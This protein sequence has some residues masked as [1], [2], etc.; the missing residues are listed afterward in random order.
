MATT[1]VKDFIDEFRRY[2]AQGERAMAQVSD[3]ALN[4]VPVAEGNSIAMIVRHIGGNLTSRFTD[5]LTTDGEKPTRDRDGEFNERSYSRGEIEASW[6]AGF[7]ALE[8]ALASI[9]EDELTRTVTIR[10]ASLTVHEALCRSLAHTAQHIGQIVL[11][12]KIAAGADW[13]TLTIPRGQS[14]LYAQNPKFEK[15]AAY[16]AAVGQGSGVGGQGSGGNS[17]GT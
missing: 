12:A 14:A 3:D 6:I 11:L 10:A 4:H 7:D 13:K 1:Y 15:A 8:R 17:K 5:F 2:R 16:A 9:P